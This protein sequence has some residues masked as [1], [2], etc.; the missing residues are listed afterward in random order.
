M[1]DS[2]G[3]LSFYKWLKL[4]N[5]GMWGYD[6]N[7]DWFTQLLAIWQVSNPK[8]YVWTSKL[9]SIW[10]NG[11]VLKQ[12]SHHFNPSYSHFSFCI[13][14]IYML[15]SGLLWHILF[16]CH[17]LVHALFIRDFMLVISGYSWWRMFE[18]YP[19][20]SFGFCQKI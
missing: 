13:F 4:L 15:L 11:E 17:Y 8:S 19:C 9:K 12:T 6:V 3:F 7:W 5:S 1:A 20:Q 10:L 18:S 2:F 14:S 16:F